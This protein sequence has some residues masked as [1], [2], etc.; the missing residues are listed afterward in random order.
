MC[1]L[2]IANVCFDV[3][4]QI[5]AYHTFDKDLRDARRCHFAA[6]LPRAQ[7]LPF[8]RRCALHFYDSFGYVVV[9]LIIVPPS[10]SIP[11][12]V[13]LHCSTR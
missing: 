13:A 9:A 1:H 3:T 10:L 11:F 8:Q 5:E 7:E 12:A 2:C 6:I 4:G